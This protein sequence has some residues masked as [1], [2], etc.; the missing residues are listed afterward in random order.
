MLTRRVISLTKNLKP[1]FSKFQIKDYHLFRD[2]AALNNIKL[3]NMEL[4]RSKSALN[5]TNM[6]ITKSNSYAHRNYYGINKYIKE[7]NYFGD[8]VGSGIDVLIVS[9]CSGIVISPLYYSVTCVY[10]KRKKREIDREKGYVYD[11]DLH[12]T[13]DVFEAMCGLLFGFIKG[14][15][16]PIFVSVYLYE[17]ASDFITTK[18]D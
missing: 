8:I 4:D 1:G 7:R 13:E 5:K 2:N 11:H 12:L 15:L 9:Y 16:S 6:K 17:K 14:V 18:K 10:D 3:N